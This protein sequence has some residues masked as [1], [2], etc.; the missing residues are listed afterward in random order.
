MGKFEDAKKIGI[1]NKETQKLIAV[2]PHK[3][4]GTDE[5]ITKAVKDWYYAQNCSAEEELKSAYVDELTDNELKS[6][7][8]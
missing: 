4:T 3:A 7:T 8:M 2:Y 6:L 5:E 1:R